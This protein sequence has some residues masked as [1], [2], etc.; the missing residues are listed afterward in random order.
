MVPLVCQHASKPDSP[1]V[2]VWFMIDTMAY[3]MYISKQT[4]CKLLGQAYS[5]T[6]ELPPIIDVKIQVNFF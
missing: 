3:D 2:N 4:M 6:V 1:I 5:P